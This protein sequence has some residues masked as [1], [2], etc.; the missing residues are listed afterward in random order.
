MTKHMGLDAS[1]LANPMR[2][3][4]ALELARE[5]RQP[6]DLAKAFA[7]LRRRVRLVILCIVIGGGISAATGLLIKPTFTATALLAVAEADDAAQSHM[8]DSA[9]DTQIAMLQSPNFMERAFRALAAD[10][11]LS[12]AAPNVGALERRMKV[13]QQSKSRLI[14]LT[15]SAKSP[16]VA[17]EA[18]NKVAR[19]YVEDPVLQSVQS[20]DDV[21]LQ[22]SARIKELEMQLDLL[23]NAGPA[24]NGAPRPDDELKTQEGLRDQIATLKLNQTLVRRRQ[25]SRRQTLA[26]TPPVQLV[27]LATPP[28]RRSSLNPLLIVAPGTLFSALFA[29]SLV[30]TLGRLDRR[31]YTREDLEELLQRKCSGEIPPDGSGKRGARKP[32]FA[33]NRAIEAVVTETLL[34]CLPRPR[35][36]VVAP[37]EANPKAPRLADDFAAALARVVP[38]VLLIDLD[39]SRRPA[40]LSMLQRARRQKAAPPRPDIFDVLAGRRTPQE[41]MERRSARSHTIIPLSSP[42]SDDPFSL[43]AS[44][45]LRRLLQDLQDQFDEIVISGPPLSNVHEA[46]IISTHADAALLLVTSAASRDT[47]IL[48]AC[49]AASRAVGF[50]SGTTRPRLWVALVEARSK[51]RQIDPL[52]IAPSL[53]PHGQAEL[54]EPEDEIRLPIRSGPIASLK[55]DARGSLS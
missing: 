14:A 25:E 37:S 4:S 26:M 7:Y 13:L 3:D 36:V 31:V 41:A 20:V 15:F 55:A 49:A 24:R 22:Y 33:Y 8:E 35:I 54:T 46:Q 12:E 2:E 29:V 11:A 9:V 18:A 51:F 34:L 1:N 48:A 32:A 30:L 40:R 39:F 42:V 17:A 45:R 27:A 21:T 6:M 50:N 16:S 28:M 47:S 10:P 44:G 23:T 43:L 5:A 53:R 19:L 52:A 38:R